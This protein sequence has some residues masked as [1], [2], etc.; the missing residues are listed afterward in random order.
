MLFCGKERTVEL[1][2][3]AGEMQK[4]LRVGRLIKQEVKTSRLLALNSNHKYK[5]TNVE[6]QQKGK[7]F[8]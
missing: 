3:F 4:K 6:I 1:L 5:K 2:E 8:W 7:H